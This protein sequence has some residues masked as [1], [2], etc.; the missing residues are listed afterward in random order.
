M[1]R[2]SKNVFEAAGR[3]K[4]YLLDHPITPANLQVTALST[5]LDAVIVTLMGH[6]NGQD[7]G[8]GSFADGSASKAEAAANLRRKMKPISKIAKELDPIQFPNV[9][10]TLR[11]PATG[12]Q[13]LQSRAETFVTTVT[14]IKAAF[15]ARGLP[16]DFDVLLDAAIAAFVAA[17]GRQSTGRSQRVQGTKGL[18]VVSKEG[19]KV[20]RELDAILFALYD[21]QPEVYAGWKTASRV[22]TVRSS[23]SAPAPTIPPAPATT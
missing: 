2:L 20:L 5:K 13:E 22:E 4:Q 17:L 1:N 10:Q 11:M 8:L 21:D 7:L 16:A 12:Y 23:P 3:S 6:R 19:R 9:R 18:S 15:T 14:P